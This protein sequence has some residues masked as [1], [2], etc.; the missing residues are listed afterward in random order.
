MKIVVTGG[1][2]Y[3]GR[4][5]VNQLLTDGHEVVVVDKSNRNCSNCVSYKNIDIFQQQD[6]LFEVLGRPDACIH[7]AWRDGFTH[8][9]INHINDLPKHYS[10]LCQLIDAGVKKVAVMGTA[11]EVGYWEGAITEDTPCNPQS[12]YGMSK[13]LLRRLLFK[14]IASTDVK[15]YWLRAYYILGDDRSNHSVFTKILEADERRDEWFPFTSGKNKFDFIHVKELAHQIA[16][17]VQQDTYSGIINVC[18]GTPISL[19]EKMED[20]IREHHLQIKL[21]YNSFPDRIDESPIVYGDNNI[22]KHIM[23]ER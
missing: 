16:A 14:K 10:F 18:S 22:I 13:D 23:E 1:N 15:L 20:F 6:D 5:V 8:E 12:L 17:V 21:K 2:G 3:I 19:G 7:M 11:H 9:S 4:H